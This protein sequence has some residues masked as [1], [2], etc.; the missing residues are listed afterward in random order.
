MK[1]N[2]TEQIATYFDL[3]G[4]DEDGLDA[5][6]RAIT[7]KMASIHP[8]TNR[9]GFPNSET[10]ELWHTLHSAKEF[11]E[12]SIASSGLESS[13]NQLIPVS[14][15]TELVKSITQAG[16]QP[17]ETRLLSLKTEARDD[18]RSRG[19]VPRIG[20]GVF[21][22]VSTFLFTF[23]SSA[24][25]HPLM[26]GWLQTTMAQYILLAA[27]FYSGI[28]FLMTWT[29]ERRQEE[30][31][32]FLSTEDGLRETMIHLFRRHSEKHEHTRR[33]TLRGLTQELMPSRHWEHYSPFLVLFGRQ[34]IS[35][36]LADKIAALHV[37]RLLKRGVVIEHPQKG[38]DR[39]FEMSGATY[40]ELKNNRWD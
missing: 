20:S 33:F 35:R 12:K 19:I 40:E 18:A 26:G 22:A 25:D 29:R 37:E 4:T 6:R 2:S 24:K 14:Q 17:V 30:L 39:V 7:K 5:L 28:F 3:R 1:W 27:M 34:Y 38:L 32:E 23:S 11:I 13:Q 9:D 8:D 15:V 31:V 10:E 16:L 36:S 21:A